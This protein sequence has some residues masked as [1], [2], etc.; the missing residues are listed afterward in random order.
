MWEFSEIYVKLHFCMGAHA[1]KKSLGLIILS[2]APTVHGLDD[3]YSPMSN[4][5][6][7]RSKINCVLGKWFLFRFF[8][9]KKG[10]TLRD[11]K[12]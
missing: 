11:F 12:V 6:C 1:L 9:K 3:A 8:F 10:L 5:V 4:E 7:G 2:K